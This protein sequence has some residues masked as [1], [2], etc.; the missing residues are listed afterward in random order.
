MQKEIN[1]EEV[2]KICNKTARQRTSVEIQYLAE[3]TNN[4]KL[5]IQL[6]E[7]QGPYSHIICCRYLKYEFCESGKYLFR[8][9]DQGTRFYI[10]ISGKVGVEVPIKDNK[11][12]THMVE[13]MVLSS[14]SGFGELAL[15]SSK[16][17]AASIKC[18]VPSHFMY[19]EKS[20]YTRL[21]SRL[22]TDRRS[23]LVDFVKSLPPFKHL[24][25]GKLTKLSYIFKEKLFTKGQIVYNEQDPAENFYII[26]KGDFEFFRTVCLKVKKIT[27]GLQKEFLF[28]VKKVAHLGVGETFGE[29]EIIQNLS[30][31][32][33]C[34]CASESAVVYEI[35]KNV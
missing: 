12:E 2:K 9:G 31:R 32:D 1:A 23:A 13:V 30:R 5:F 8:F 6:N 15:E 11:G 28:K 25:K 29:L 3:L 24:T 14:G 27:N 4:L 33:C 10:I 21:I 18:K 16:P 22:V 7:S 19:L 26:K 34:K 35:A 20:D 17:R